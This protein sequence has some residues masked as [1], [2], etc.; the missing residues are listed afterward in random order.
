LRFP[1]SGADPVKLLAYWQ[2]HR[3]PA[4]NDKIGPILERLVQEAGVEAPKPKPAK[5]KTAARATTSVESDGCPSDLSREMKAF[6]RRTAEV[7]EVDG[8]SILTVACRAWDRAEDA[9]LGIAQEGLKST[10]G[11]LN[12]LVAVEAQAADRYLRALKQLGLD[13]EPITRSKR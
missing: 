9:R 1:L 6:W 4:Y 5:A 3:D 13:V 7:L 12:P 10:N 11:R 8:Q 2:A